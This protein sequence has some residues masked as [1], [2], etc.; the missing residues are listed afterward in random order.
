MA[1]QAASKLR[2]APP[3]GRMP[4]RQRMI[5]CANECLVTSGADMSVLLPESGWSSG[6]AASARILLLAR[7]DPSPAMAVPAILGQAAY[8]PLTSQAFVVAQP[9]RGVDWSKTSGGLGKLTRRGLDAVKAHVAWTFAVCNLM[10]IGGSDQWW[11]PA[12]T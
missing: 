4:V 2:L 7:L 11:E 1:L 6:S 3:P 10:R 5:A 8:T 9:R 12:P